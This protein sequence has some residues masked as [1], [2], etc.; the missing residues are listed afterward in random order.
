MRDDL[1]VG[2]RLADP[3]GYELG[4]L[5]SVVDDQDRA[6]HPT[7]VYVEPQHLPALG[8]AARGSEGLSPYSCLV[9]H[10]GGIKREPRTEAT[11]AGRRMSRC[12]RVD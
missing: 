11:D 4:V 2:P 5:G 12:V 7:S 8:L 10:N 6:M 3:T 1:A 9:A